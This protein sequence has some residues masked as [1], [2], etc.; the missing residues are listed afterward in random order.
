MQHPWTLSGTLLGMAACAVLA[1]CGT[2]G[3]PIDSA[4]VRAAG[5]SVARG[6]PEVPLVP[7]PPPPL[8][9]EAKVPP[10]S[11]SVPSSPAPPPAAPVPAATTW[12]KS[13]PPLTTPVAATGTPG[14]GAVPINTMAPAPARRPAPAG[15]VTARQLYQT[16]SERIGPIDS[17]IVRLTRREVI[18]DKMNPE[19]V[20]LFKFRKNP[21]SVY[22]KWLGKE[23]QGRE[24]V[25]VRGRYEGKIH[26]LLAAGDIPLVPAGRRMAL[27]P[28]SILVRSACRHPIT[29]AGIGA[30]VDRIGS[31]IAANER[32]DR[33]LGSMVLLTDVRRPEFNRPVNALEHSFPPGYDVSLPKGGKRTYYF[34]PVTGLP[35]LIRTFDERGAEVEYYRYDRLLTGVKLD[36]ADFDPDTLWGKPRTSAGR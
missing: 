12:T 17:Y 15:A 4:R 31:V 10:P 32:G 9:S 6:E 16:A 11:S 1:G 8:G 20:L 5:S 21:W 28:D 26:T 35:T 13:P 18:K 23:G 7:V 2:I 14:E 27:P 3:R 30:S 25:Y 29:Q 36:D 33:R 24:V 34:D 19:E 22:L